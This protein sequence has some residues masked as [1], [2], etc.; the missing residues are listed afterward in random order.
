[1]CAYLYRFASPS[2]FLTF[3]RLIKS[4]RVPFASGSQIFLP[5]SLSQLLIIL[6]E[7]CLRISKTF[8]IGL[9]LSLMSFSTNARS[10]TIHPKFASLLDH[11][12]SSRFRSALQS[13]EFEFS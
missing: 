2:P 3:Q 10:L 1:M 12:S 9:C 6:S 13:L 4:L 8:V 5:L 11:G 7:N